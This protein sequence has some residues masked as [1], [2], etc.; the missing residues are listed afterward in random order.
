M[1]FSPVAIF[2]RLESYNHPSPSTNQITSLKNGL[3]LLIGV[4][5]H[6]WV[7]T[8][9][10]PLLKFVFWLE[11]GRGS[12]IAIFDPLGQPK[13]TAGR[14]NSFRTGCPYVRPSPLFQYRK[15]KQ[16]KQCSLLA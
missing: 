11:L 1:H 7:G 6:T 14:D 15:T 8:C 4:F 10:E 2:T 16:K 12:R 9:K 13:V 5:V 3:T